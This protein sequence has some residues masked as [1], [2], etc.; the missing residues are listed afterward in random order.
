MRSVIIG[1]GKIGSYLARQLSRAGH[2]VTLIEEDPERAQQVVADT[3]VLVFEGD[4]TDVAFLRAADV[5]RADWVVPVTGHDEVNLAA[6]QLAKTLGAKRVIA[7]LNDPANRATFEAL[8][9]PVV[10][11][12]G[13]IAKVLTKEV[14][15]AEIAR[16]D[17]FAGGRVIVQ[18]IDVPEDFTTRAVV[19]LSLPQDALL[20][21]VVRGDDV[22]LAR[23]DTVVQGGDRI[24][25]ASTIDNAAAVVAAFE[26]ERKGS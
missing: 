17:L 18:E 25:A 21:T 20:V 6:A 12:T 15:I 16:S 11:V 8:E 13:L 24:L 5:D 22:S 14:E 3:K 4:G 26:V 19:D 10:G 9:I 23:G 7:R 1:G 2:F